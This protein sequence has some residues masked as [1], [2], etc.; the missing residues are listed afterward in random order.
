[1]TRLKPAAAAGLAALALASCARSGVDPMSP[2]RPIRPPSA[3][4]TGRGEYRR[5]RAGRVAGGADVSGRHR[6]PGGR[7]GRASLAGERHGARGSHTPMLSEPRFPYPPPDVGRDKFTSV[8]RE[9]V[10]DRLRGAGLDLLD[11]RRHRL[12]F[13]RPRLAQPQ[14]PAAAGRGADRGDDQLF[15]LRLCRAARRAAQPFSTNVAVFPSPWTPGRKLVRI[16]I[17]GYAVAARHAAARQ[18]RLPDRHVGLDERARTSCRWSSSR[19]PCCS[20]SSTRDDTRRDRHLCRQRRHR[21]RAD[22]G[23]P[24]G[25][26]SAR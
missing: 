16:G 24:E 19:W 17:K 25:A 10:Q 1:M 23:Q 15:P 20:T 6:L 9:S 3:D 26:G 7:D 5:Y 21:A 14:R 2:P 11:R 12:L 22:P 18:P 13:V 4:A 8:S